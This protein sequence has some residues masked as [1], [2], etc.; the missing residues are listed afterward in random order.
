MEPDFAQVLE[1]L[2]KGSSVDEI[3]AALR[4]ATLTEALKR[5]SVVR[6]FDQYLYD[7][8]L[9]ASADAE[10][11]PFDD[12]R[13]C[14]EV[15]QLPGPVELFR[16]RES[17]RRTAWFSWWSDGSDAHEVP[18]PLREL[19]E[20]LAV[21]YE[22]IASAEVDL[23]A[24]LV[25]VDQRRAGKWFA[26]RF[27]VA[28]RAFQLARCQDLVDVLA[29][30]GRAQLLGTELFALGQHRAAHLQA[31]SMWS[32]EYLQTGTFLEMSGTRA[33]YLN[34]LRRGGPRLMQVH[35]RGGQGKTMELRWLLS[36]VL[37]PDRVPCAATDFDFVDLANAAKYPWLVLIDIA[38]QLDQQLTRA[39][40]AD[41]LAVHGYAIALLRRRASEEERS[42][43]SKW[44]K[45]QDDGLRDLV[46]NTFVRTF[47]SALADRS[48]VIVFDTLEEL[49]LRTGNGL[50]G[51]MDVVRAVHDRCRT[52]HFVLAGRY[53]VSERMSG[54]PSIADRTPGLFTDEDSGRY[55]TLRGIEGSDLQA[56]ITAK[57]AG[58]PFTLALLADLAQQR[59]NLTAHDVTKFE[60]DLI[61]LVLRVISRIQDPRV[62][63]LLRYGVVP[64]RLTFEFVVD[65]ME[66]YL[67]MG[68]SGDTEVDDPETDELPAPLDVTSTPFHTNVLDSA[69]SSLPLDLVWKELRRYA[70]TSS[71]VTEQQDELRF[72]PDVLVPMRRLIR[73]REIHRRLHEDAVAYFELRAGEDPEQWKRWTTEAIFHQFQLEGAGAAAYWRSALDR[74]ELGDADVRA[75]LADEVL[76]RDYLDDDGQPLLWDGSEP[77]ISPET[78]VEA[79]YE[80]AAASTQEAR[81]LG[82]VDDDQRWSQVVEQLTLIERSGLEHVIPEHRLAYVRAALK[83]QTGDS[84]A[85]E[86]LVR[87]ALPHARHTQ[88]E[89]RLYVLLADIRLQQGFADAPSLYLRAVHAAERLSAWKWAPALRCRVVRAHQRL[90]QL[91]EAMRE[92]ELILADVDLPADQRAELDLVAVELGLASGRLTWAAEHAHKPDR[93]SINVEAAQVALARRDPLSAYSRVRHIG[94]SLTH[95]TSATG[96]EV[97]ARS[98]AAVAEYPQALLELELARNIWLTRGDSAGAA[99]CHVSS[100]LV[101]MRDLGD[102]AAADTHFAKAMKLL[103]ESDDPVRLSYYLARVELLGRRREPEAAMSLLRSALRWLDGRW[104]PPEMFVLAA[105][106]G[107]A[108]GHPDWSVPFLELLEKNLPLIT[109]VSARLRALRELGRIE[110]LPSEELQDRLVALR[111]LLRLSGDEDLTDADQAEL[112]FVSVELDRLTA[113]TTDAAGRLSWIRHEYRKGGSH[114]FVREWALATDRL[115]RHRSQALPNNT[116]VDAFV[117][118]FREHRMLCFEFLV[119]R[120]EAELVQERPKQ[121][122]RLLD[123]AEACLDRAEGTQWQARHADAVSRTI[124]LDKQNTEDWRP[125]AVTAAAALAALGLAVRGL[126]RTDATETSQIVVPRCTARIGVSAKGQVEVET[127]VP[128]STEVRHQ[129][130]PNHDVGRTVLA[131]DLDER[132]VRDWQKVGAE[133]GSALLP[134]AA[135]AALSA[136]KTPLGF[137]CDIEDRRLDAVPWELS[138][139][140]GGSQ[141]VTLSPSVAALYRTSGHTTARFE[142]ARHV[143]FALNRLIGAK[144]VLDGE[145]GP[146][147]VSALRKWRERQHLEPSDVINAEVLDRLQRGLVEFSR[148]R[149]LILSGNEHGMHTSRRRLSTAEDIARIYL[150]FGFINISVV[151]RPTMPQL[152]Y[153]VEQLVSNGE[154][155][156]IVHLAGGIKPSPDGV[157]MTFGSFKSQ[158]SA[159]GVD[160]LL[161]QLPADDV[162]PLVVLDVDRPSSLVDTAR[163]LL[164]RNAYAGELF[165]LGRCSG[166]LGTGLADEE[167]HLLVNEMIESFA[168][169][170]SLGETVRRLRSLVRDDTGIDRVLAFAGTTLHTHLPW[171]RFT[172]GG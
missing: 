162:R 57:A 70:S 91:W 7:S 45:S 10:V 99:R 112:D 47:N 41:F 33:D 59:L 3:A 4:P 157:A 30:E 12:V 118:E 27:D 88:D 137:R 19:G 97:A 113:H 167:R 147:T 71:W 110:D 46:V 56:A 127:F 53:A 128:P 6:A 80:L 144:L 36:R 83:F 132:L 124:Q 152:S 163:Y 48:V 119:E 106:E 100:A 78:V 145:I 14:A 66:P 62:R 117:E 50:E 86:A 115:R 60:A 23:L 8:V 131:D 89:V 130:S 148:S 103:G 123:R 67:R 126:R 166:V 122:R 171:L 35:A 158:L 141:F 136:G 108:L 58:R 63:W 168:T 121:A 55:L 102:L 37:V 87:E 154:R 65:V 120:A 134:S 25:L 5:C 139:L 92:L 16:L 42:A 21:H 13:C 2:S 84:A 64:R 11:A 165:A 143:Q 105:V 68:M 150:R 43:A 20:R 135:P 72:H 146:Q 79:R 73:P 9:T 28:D 76:C 125:Y 133:L 156:G 161:A 98:S 15:E 93:H 160:R 149:V 109:P 18:E 51:L 61:Y 31:R 22:G 75:H 169:G 52:A 95:H 32:A 82:V 17:A 155:L 104:N 77:V 34:L 114:Y 151:E 101:N 172:G 96:L 164:L 69:G 116:T 29:D 49:H 111:P 38:F 107:L 26:D 44:V 129:F 142:E 170:D 140:R 24:A 138:R 40:F 85:A 74:V 90:G 1:L 94:E 39:P 81:V 153:M 54:L 159:T